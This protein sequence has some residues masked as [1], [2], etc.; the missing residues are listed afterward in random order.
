GERGA[1]RA[2]L[3][4]RR[5]PSAPCTE[6]RSGR[7]GRA[8]APATTTGRPRAASRRIGSLP[9]R[10]SR[11]G[12]RSRAA[13]IRSSGGAKSP[14]WFT[15]MPRL[16]IFSGVTI[17]ATGVRPAGARRSE[18]KRSGPA[19]TRIVIQY[20]MPSVDDGRYPSKRCVGDEVRVEADVFRDGHDLLRTLVRYRAPGASR[21]RETE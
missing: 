8:A 11:P 3:A 12:A 4:R 5:T 17:P 10:V 19:A 16:D 6:T 14:H 18:P 9:G 2:A 21:W 15:R 20:P 7:A 13:A 1:R